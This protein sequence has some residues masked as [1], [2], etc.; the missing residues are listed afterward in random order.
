[1]AP[2]RPILR[3]GL[4]GGI[5]SGKT[6]VAGIL[7]ERQLFLEVSVEAKQR[8]AAAGYDPAYG[9]RPL[10]RAIQKQVLDPLALELIEGRLDPGDTVR[11]DHDGDR[12]TFDRV[13]AGA[14]EATV[15]G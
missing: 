15:Q 5:A 8:L 12:F 1:M 7:A 10:K 4:T 6:T 13:P 9:A 14:T 2:S 3:V 11:L